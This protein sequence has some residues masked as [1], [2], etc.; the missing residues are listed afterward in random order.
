MKRRRIAALIL[1]LTLA[2]LPLTRYAAPPL[3]QLQGEFV[4]VGG[5][6]LH[7]IRSGIGKK[8]PTVV[9]ECGLFGCAA[10]WGW[11]MRE[12]SRSAPVV[13]YDRAGLGWS[14]PAPGENDGLSA[15]THLTNSWPRP[16]SLPPISWSDIRTAVNW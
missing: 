8:G 13:A 9:L 5:H 7:L 12:L 16:R 4:D 14:D 10:N 6:R 15:V 2:A 3:P 11:I 1:T